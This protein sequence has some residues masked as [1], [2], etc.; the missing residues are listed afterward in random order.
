VTDLAH[1]SA[2]AQRMQRRA[3]D[4]TTDA[5]RRE[6]WWRVWRVALM[7]EGVTP[8]ISG[9]V[10][11]TKAGLFGPLWLFVAVRGA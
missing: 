5:L 9:V 11:L 10:T 2:A 1:V 3:I 8:L 6:A 4:D 7:T